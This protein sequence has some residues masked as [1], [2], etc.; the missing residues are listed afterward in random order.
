MWRVTTLSREPF[1]ANIY[2][3]KE[4]YDRKA[5]EAKGWAP[6]RRKGEN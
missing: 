1:N 6:P 2:D 3:G 5:D 4:R